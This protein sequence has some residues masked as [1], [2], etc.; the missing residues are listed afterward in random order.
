MEF[1]DENKGLMAKLKIC[2]KRHRVIIDKNLC[3]RGDRI[4]IG[5]SGGKDIK[6]SNRAIAVSLAL[7]GNMKCLISLKAF[8]CFCT[9]TNH[10]SKMFT[11]HA[12]SMSHTLGTSIFVF[13]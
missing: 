10:M 3:K 13:T 8:R 9:H 12:T 2:K 4:A 7:E 11:F 5:A 6:G 1:E